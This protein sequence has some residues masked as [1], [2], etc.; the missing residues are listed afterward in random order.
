MLTLRARKRATHY[1]E[2]RGNKLEWIESYQKTS[3]IH[4][5]WSRMGNI[6]I[7]VTVFSCCRRTVDLELRAMP[8]E[9][10]YCITNQTIIESRVFKTRR[11]TSQERLQVLFPTAVFPA[12]YKAIS[13][14]IAK[15][16]CK[17]FWNPLYFIIRKYHLPITTGGLDKAYSIN[18]TIKN[19]ASVFKR[20]PIL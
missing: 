11:P 6:I 3:R 15:S 20:P 1:S 8:C 17:S 10:T 19:T 4:Q 9:T 5:S 2:I 14:S 16:N 18:V 7:Y 12:T 13:A